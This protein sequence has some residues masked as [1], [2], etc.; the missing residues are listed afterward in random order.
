MPK[1]TGSDRTAWLDDPGIVGGKQK[2]RNKV[3]VL[4]NCV[5]TQVCHFLKYIGL[6]CPG[7]S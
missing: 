6:N 4:A 2:K 3:E 1:L 7:P 5:Y